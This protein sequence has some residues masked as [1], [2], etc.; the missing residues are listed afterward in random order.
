M[1]FSWVLLVLA[2]A[3]FVSMV[4]LAIVCLDCRNSGPQVSIRQASE[5]YM[6]S[7]DFRV[8]HSA[9][10][11]TDVS[12]IHS[13]STLLSPFPHSSDPG[14]QRRQRSVTPTETESIPS[15]ENSPDVPNYVNPGSYT[16]P[17]YIL[18]LADGEAPPNNPSRASTHSSDTQHDYENVQGELAHMSLKDDD[19][20]DEDEDDGTG[21]YLNVDALHTETPGESSQSESDDEDGGNYV[22][23]PPLMKS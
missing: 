19:D 16:D 20:D 3:V 9:Q 17:D 7:T 22:N 14:T 6:P 15:Y 21:D 11:T 1:D 5:I 8:I 18:V 10:Q 13:P 12:S 2:V 23:Q 4:V